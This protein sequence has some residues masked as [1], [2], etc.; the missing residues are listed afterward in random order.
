[1]MQTIERLEMPSDT[2]RALEQIAA[3][4]GVTPLRVVE[5]WLQQH[6]TMENLR[7]L[8][9]EYLE[10]IDK[11]LGRTMTQQDAARLALVCE[12]LNAV[13]MQSETAQNWQ[14]QADAID[15]KF[16]AIE[17]EIAALPERQKKARS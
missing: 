8:R 2:Y 10:L 13:E 11:D 7:E 4:Q 14:R 9:R 17:R 12:E 6:R 5:G 16:D 15:A 1:M 3:F